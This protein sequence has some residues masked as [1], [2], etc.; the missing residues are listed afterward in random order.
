MVMHSFMMSKV[1]LFE[2]TLHCHDCHILHTMR[3]L[4]TARS[5]YDFCTT[6]AVTCDCFGKSQTGNSIQVLELKTLD[7]LMVDQA[8]AKYWCKDA[9]ANLLA[10]ARSQNNARCVCQL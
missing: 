9:V 1:V 6:S 4:C 3:H 7:M 2:K 5:L 8:E 10:F